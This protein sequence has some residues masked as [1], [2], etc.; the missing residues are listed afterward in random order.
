MKK[1]EATNLT[2]VPLKLEEQIRHKGFPLLS[3]LPQGHGESFHMAEMFPW[4]V[5]SPAKLH[6]GF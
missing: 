1:P 5:V 2:T 3:S 6:S 4:L